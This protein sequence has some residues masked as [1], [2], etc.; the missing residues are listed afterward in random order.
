M[1]NAH[2]NNNNRLT[3]FHMERQIPNH[4][5]V[6]CFFKRNYNYLP[7]LGLSVKSVILRYFLS[8]RPRKCSKFCNV[9]SST[10]SFKVGS[11]RTYLKCDICMLEVYLLWA[12]NVALHVAAH[13]NIFDHNI[14]LWQLHYMNLQEVA[15]FVVCTTDY[16]TQNLCLRLKHVLEF[17]K[18]LR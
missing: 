18:V 7:G 12:K 16:T 10:A 17:R 1:L 2:N 6:K 3:N 9:E 14:F 8:G 5:I 4:Q 13:R 11:F 15:V